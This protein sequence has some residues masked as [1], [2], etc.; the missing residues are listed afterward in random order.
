VFPEYSVTVVVDYPYTRDPVEMAGG[1]FFHDRTDLA[2]GGQAPLGLSFTRSYI[3]SKHLDDRG[4]GNGWTHNY[5]ISLSRLSHGN[6]GLGM[7]QPVDAAALISALYINLD[8]MRNQ[9]DIKGWMVSSLV[10]KWAVDQLIDNAVSVRLGNKSMEFIKLSNGSYAA[11]P[12]ITT[13]LVD[14]GTSFS[15]VEWFGTTMDFNGDDTVSQIS[16][17]HGNSLTI[18]T[19]SNIYDSLGRV[20]TQTVPR[21][22]GTTV[23]DFYF[24]GFRNLEKDEQGNETIYYFDERGRSTGAENAL[25]HKSRKAYDG[26]DHLVEVMDPRLNTTLFQYDGAHNLTRVIDNDLNETATD[27]QGK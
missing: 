12:G 22:T 13:E 2:L 3:S 6:P 15:L 27:S 25:G 10:N 7:R 4:M 1:S 8:L 11:P 5:D 20:K 23:Y 9:D 21:Q 26:Q 17:I 14:N 19:A 24:S 16:D 18:T